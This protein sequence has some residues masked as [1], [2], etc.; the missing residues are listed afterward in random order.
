MIL[1]TFNSTFGIPTA[2]HRIVVSA[3]YVKELRISVARATD[4]EQV[5]FRTVQTVQLPGSM[6][7]LTIWSAIFPRLECCTKEEVRKLEFHGPT[8]SRQRSGRRKSRHG[9]TRPSIDS[10]RT[11]PNELTCHKTLSVSGSTQQDFY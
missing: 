10:F 8:D 3:V 1:S 9:S 4:T 7:S 5:E 2:L 11:S 6:A